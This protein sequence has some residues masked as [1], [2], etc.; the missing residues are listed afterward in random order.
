[1]DP[2]RTPGKAEGS[3]EDADIA[4]M[5]DEKK[6]QAMAQKAQQCEQQ[7]LAQEPGHTPGSAEGTDES[8]GSAQRKP[9]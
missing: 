4:L 2:K 5:E 6:R 1:M 3:E 7:Q 8:A 9:K